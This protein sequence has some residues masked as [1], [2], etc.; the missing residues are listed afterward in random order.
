MDGF[1]LV[2]ETRKRAMQGEAIP[3]DHII[4][5]FAFAPESRECAFLGEQAHDVAS[6]VA[7]NTGRIWSAVGVDCSPCDMS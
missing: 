5:L 6:C 3:R 4:R 7:A 2:R 1:E